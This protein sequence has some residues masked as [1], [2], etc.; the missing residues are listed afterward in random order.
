MVFKVMPF[1]D[2]FGAGLRQCD[3]WLVAV[4]ACQDLRLLLVY[5]RRNWEKG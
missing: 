1:I 2:L 3:G 4:V 5:E